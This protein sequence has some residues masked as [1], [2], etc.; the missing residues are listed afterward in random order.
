MPYRVV[1][2]E[3]LAPTLTRLV[4]EAPLVA[5]KRQAGHFVMV[6]LDETGERIPLTIVDSSSDAITLIVQAVGK[7]TKMLAARRAGE[8]IADVVGPLGNPTP[9][10][11]HGHVACVGGGVGVA[12]LLPIATALRGNGDSVHAILG[13][14][15]RDLVILESQMAACSRTLVITT[16]DGS[17]GLKGLATDALRSVLD[18]HPIAAVYAIGPLAMMKAVTELTRG[19]Q[20]RTWVSLNAIMIDGTG[21]CGGCRVSVGGEM[22]FACVDGPEFDAHLVDFD[23][24]MLRNRMYVDLERLA[25][26]RCA[27][28]RR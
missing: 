27:G 17:L 6:R 24:L 28:A 9:V 23:E 7:T 22:K 13:A 14:R 5:R 3:R 16:E 26:E 15:S 18:E 25:D 1:E 11:R 20:I 10:G 8:W 2:A 21:M 4:V 12:E 19:R